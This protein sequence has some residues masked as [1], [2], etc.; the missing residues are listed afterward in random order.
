MSDTTAMIEVTATMLPS[1]VMNERS[2]A[3]QIALSAIAADS[4]YFCM[5]GPVGWLDRLIG[6]FRS[7]DLAHP[8]P[9]DLPGLPAPR[10]PYLN[11]PRALPS[12]I[13]T[14]SPS[15]RARTEL[16]GPVTT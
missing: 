3:D 2:L 13:L 4:R 1:T 14:V 10:P 6:S 9:P 7:A 15:A 5:T 12:S 11:H 8:G 16:Y